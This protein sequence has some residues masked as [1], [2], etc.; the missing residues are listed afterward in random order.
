MKNNNLIILVIATIITLFFGWSY[1]YAENLLA[2]DS[3]KQIVLPVPLSNFPKEIGNWD[4]KDIELSDAVKK[5]AGNDDFV[6]RSYINEKEGKWVG[7]YVAY[8]GQPRNMLGH[9]PQVCYPGAGWIH[10][11]TKE[12]V[13]TS[14]SGKDIPC[15]IHKFRKPFPDSSQVTVMNF[16]ILNGIPTNKEAEFNSLSFRMPNIKGEVAHYVSQIQINSAVESS[17]VEFAPLIADMVLE[18]LPDQD[19]NVAATEKQEAKND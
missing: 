7:F 9:R 12:S 18:Y 10:E 16:Y 11:S 13:F 1:R 5:V 2:K 19:G 4:G 15:L 17:V 3:L 14:Q 8:A 6:N